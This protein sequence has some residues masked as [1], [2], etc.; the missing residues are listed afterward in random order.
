MLYDNHSS[1]CLFSPSD[2]AECVL[3]ILRDSPSGAA[4]KVVVNEGRSYVTF[5][6]E[7]CAPELPK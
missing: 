7:L 5:P 3:Q 1:V 4:M 6:P 2:V